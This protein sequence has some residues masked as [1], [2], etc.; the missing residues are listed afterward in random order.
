MQDLIKVTTNEEGQ[1]LVS[2]RELHEVLKVQQD[3]SDWIKKQLNSVD[4]NKDEDITVIWHDP[5][6]KV[7]SF[8]GNVNSMTRQGYKVDYILTLDI[9]KEVCMCVGVAPRTNE[10]TRKLSK[11]VRKYFI[12][13]ERIAKQKAVPALS[14]EQAFVLDV[15][16]KRNNIGEFALALGSYGD[17]K[18]EEGGSFICNENII[19]LIRVGEMIQHT[20]QHEFEELQYYPTKAQLG[21]EFNR[22]LVHKNYLEPRLFNNVRGTGKEKRKHLQPTQA[23]YDVFVAQ[24]MATAREV[25]DGRGKVEVLFTNNVCKY[26]LSDTFKTEF[27]KYIQKKCPLMVEIPTLSKTLDI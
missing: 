23:F 20:F 6:K 25:L 18:F 13:C 11:Q 1:Q 26:I 2:G 8:N 24:A 17:F 5:F 7:V 15:F 19:T 14:K 3:Y 16:N 12:E 10:E 9:A 21:G 22:F 4:A 27:M